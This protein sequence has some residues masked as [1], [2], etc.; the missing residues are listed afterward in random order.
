M[1]DDIHHK[2]ILAIKDFSER[3]REIVRSG[4]IVQEAHDNR[5]RSLE[6]QVMQLKGMIQALQVKIYS[7]GATSQ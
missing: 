5:I 3:T 6:E 4:Q 7:G 2:N 1:S